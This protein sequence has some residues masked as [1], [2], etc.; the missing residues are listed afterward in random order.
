MIARFLIFKD[1]GTEVDGASEA[2][3]GGAMQRFSPGGKARFGKCDGQNAFHVG[4]QTYGAAF[5]L[6]HL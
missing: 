3:G 5:P 2:D 1:M 6:K 4:P